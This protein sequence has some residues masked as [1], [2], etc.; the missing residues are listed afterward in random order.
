MTKVKRSDIDANPP[1]AVRKRVEESLAKM[2]P[3]K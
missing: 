2:R 3:K 1:E